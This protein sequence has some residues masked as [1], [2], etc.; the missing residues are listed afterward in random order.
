MTMFVSEVALV[1]HDP[2]EDVN[3]FLSTTTSHFVLPMFVL[4]LVCCSVL[5][6]DMNDSKQR[7]NRG[8]LRI[9]CFPAHT[10]PAHCD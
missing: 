2:T 9:I 4:H 8:S 6:F 3:V 7:E 5:Q 10:I 1:C